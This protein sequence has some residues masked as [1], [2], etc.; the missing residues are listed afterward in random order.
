[1]DRRTF[2]A[3]TG[4]MLLVAPL[5]A[6]GQQGERIRRVGLYATTDPKRWFLEGCGNSVG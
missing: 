4:A 2:L 6:E 5:A 1:M 3:G